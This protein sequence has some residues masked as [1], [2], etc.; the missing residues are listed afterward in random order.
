MIVEYYKPYAAHINNLAKRHGI[1][2]VTVNKKTNNDDRYTLAACSNKYEMYIEIPDVNNEETY[3]TALHEIGHCIHP[4]GTHGGYRFFTDNTNLTEEAAAWSWAFAK[5]KIKVNPTDCEFA[6]W[7][8][9]T[10]TYNAARFGY[11]EPYEVPHPQMES[12][13]K[14]HQLLTA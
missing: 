7:C 5:S 10:Y 11:Q 13:K 4:L 2:V 8:Y 6:R 9:G 14:M 1:R 12:V 3:L